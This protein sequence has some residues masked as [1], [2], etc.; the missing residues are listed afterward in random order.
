MPEPIKDLPGNPNFPDPRFEKP[1]KRKSL[2]LRPSSIDAMI[3]EGAIEEV[4]EPGSGIQYDDRAAAL[5]DEAEALQKKE[6]EH[7]QL[8]AETLERVR[9]VRE[10][11]ILL[12]S[13]ERLLDKREAILSARVS[14][15]SSDA[16]IEALEQSLEETRNTLATA[17][18]VLDEKEE[19][20]TGLREEIAELESTLDQVTSP[21]QATTPVQEA[22]TKPSDYDSITDMSLQEQVAFLKER[23]AFIEQSENVLFDKAQNLQ[24]WETRLQQI[25]HDQVK[26]ELEAQGKGANAEGAIE[27]PRSVASS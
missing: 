22:N 7:A 26:A 24:E 11:E 18:K 9:I 27:F 13:R 6:K 10:T 16:D 1:D 2:R 5:R 21:D 3:R 23:E 8:L 17:N 19:V 25:Q 14:S 12:T 15:R 20:I 4:E